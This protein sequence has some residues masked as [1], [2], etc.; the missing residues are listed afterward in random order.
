MSRKIAFAIVFVLHSLDTGLVD[1]GEE[2]KNHI[3]VRR[4]SFFSIRSG[5]ET[6]GGNFP[7]SLQSALAASLNHASLASPPKPRGLTSSRP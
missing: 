3:F 1:G 7:S 2:G 4:A 5:C 6:N